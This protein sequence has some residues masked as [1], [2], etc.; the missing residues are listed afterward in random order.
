MIC[1]ISLGI[2]VATVQHSRISP[3]RPVGCI[4]DV[5][6][7]ATISI[8]IISV[9]DSIPKSRNEISST[10]RMGIKEN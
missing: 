5:D 8:Q 4:C 2:R 10:Y 9:S 1:L 7:L 6:N 3:G